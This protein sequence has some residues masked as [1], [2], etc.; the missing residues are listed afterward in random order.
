MEFHTSPMLVSLESGF[1]SKIDAEDAYPV[2]TKLKPKLEKP[3]IAKKEVR[4]TKELQA[5]VKP[6]MEILKTLYEGYLSG[7]RPSEKLET[8]ASQF[9]RTVPEIASLIDAGRD[10]AITARD[11]QPAFSKLSEHIS[12][13]LRDYRKALMDIIPASDFKGALD[14]L[15]MARFI[16]QCEATVGRERTNSYSNLFWT[17]VV[18]CS[19]GYL[20]GWPMVVSHLN[21]GC[22]G[23]EAHE[24]GVIPASLPRIAIVLNKEASVRAAQLIT[25]AG[26][27]PMTATLSNMDAK[28]SLFVCASC[29]SPN[30]KRFFVYNWRQ[31]VSLCSLFG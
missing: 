6:R 11:F 22:V 9:L 5:I 31:A 20:F 17:D 18:N 28:D 21:A 24:K 8:P 15:H 2:W 30:S 25:L 29:S 19:S 23:A 3:V 16:F 12:R 14:P 13:Y 27:D 4:L 1:A 10:T 26:L 7:L